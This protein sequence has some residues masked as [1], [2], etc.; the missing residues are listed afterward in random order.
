MAA[1]PR[2]RRPLPDR[3]RRAR[4]EDPARRRGAGREPAGVGGHDECPVRRRMDRSRHQLRRLHPDH[5]GPP[6]DLGAGVPPAG[7]RQRLHRARD[8]RGPLLRGLRGVLHRGRPRRRPVPGARASGGDGHRGELLLPALEVRA[9]A[10]R[11]LRGPSGGGP[12]RRQAQRGPRLHPPGPAGL[13]DEPH[14]DLLGDPPPVGPRPR[15]LRL[16]RRAHQLRDRGG[17]RHGPRAVRLPLARPVPPHRQGHPPLPR[18]L[19]AGHADG[20]RAGGAGVRVRPRLPARGRREDEQD[21]PQ[22]DRAR[23]SHPGVRQRRVPVPPRG[24]RPLRSGRRLQLRGD[25]RALQRRSREQLRQPGESRAQHGGV[26][27]RRDRARDPRRRSARAADRDRGRG[28]G[29]R[30]RAPRLLGR[31]RRGVAAH[32]RRERVHRGLAALGT[33]QGRRRDG[34]CR[35]PRRLPRG[36]AGRRD[37]RVAPDPRAARELWA[38]LGL[39]GSPEDVRLPDAVRWGSVHTAGNALEKGAS[40]FPRLDG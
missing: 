20:G 10:A 28:D 24:R 27:L 4:A 22:P 21:E 11:P 31:L 25:G 13:L 36:A 35:G 34:R 12:T 5:R 33:A 23:G 39:D 3:D 1:A 30:A 40:L 14:L 37:P 2:R 32:P 16:V 18:R 17:L 8:L 38:R 6:P 29:G 15:H 19:L 7:V 9:A 26:V